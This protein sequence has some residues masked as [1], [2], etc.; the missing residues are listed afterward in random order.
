[1]GSCFS[2]P[3]SEL[4]GAVGAVVCAFNRCSRLLLQAFNKWIDEQL[5]SSPQP[6]LSV[7]PEGHRS[8]HGESLPLKRGML[9]YAYSRKLPVQIVIGANKEAIISEKHCTARFNQTAVV[10]YSGGWWAAGGRAAGGRGAGV[11]G[12]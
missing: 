10:G 5:D 1:M 6:G 8:T 12:E 11:G 4:H 3:V 7:Y 9:Y 2:W